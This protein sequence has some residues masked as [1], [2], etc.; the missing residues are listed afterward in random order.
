VPALEFKDLS[1][2][3]T[4]GKPVLE[5]TSFK[6][7]RGESICIVGPNGGGKST[8]IKLILG[9][10]QPTSGEVL[11]FGASP[12]TM[13]H[14]VGYMPQHL[15]FDPQFPITVID[16]VLMGRLRTGLALGPFTRNDR[17]AA[18]RALEKVDLENRARSRFSELSGGQRQRALIARALV[19]DPD[20]LLLDEPTANVDQT[21][22]RQFRE[23]LRSLAGE[24]SIVLVSH[25]LSF[26]SSWLGHVLCVNRN[27]HMHPTA[28]IDGK[29][30]QEIFGGDIVAVQH[31]HD[32]PP[33]DHVHHHG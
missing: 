2:S 16:V 24:M 28:S 20:L 6:L 14:R 26:V 21:V 9:L 23:T 25:D 12:Q 4:P 15:S 31:D 32:C 5:K 1:F 33:G 27:V 11:V 17:A 29:T 18:I 7:T 22:E 30:L 10:Q 8:L 3:Y 13:R 19:D